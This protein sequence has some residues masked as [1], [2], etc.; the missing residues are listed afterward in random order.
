MGALIQRRAFII[1]GLASTH[2]LTS[3]RAEPSSFDAVVGN[4]GPISARRFATIHQAIDAAPQNPDRPF[5]IFIANGEW[6]ERLIIDKPMIHL[7]GESQ[8]GTLI[9]FDLAAGMPGEDGQPL[10]TWGCASVVIKAPGFGAH[11][12]TIENSFDYIGHL[13]RPRFERVGP[14]GAQAVAAM[15]TDQSDKAR[16]EHVTFLG[17]QDTLFIDRGRADFWCCAIFGSVDFIFGGGAAWFEQS[18]IVSRYRPGQ[19]RNHGYLSAP[20]TSVDLPFGFVFKNCRLDREAQVPDGA[21]VLGRPWRPTRQFAD[22]VY[23]DPKAVGSSYYVDCWMGA[24]ISADGWDEMGYTAPDGQRQMLQ[25]SDARFGESGSAGPGAFKNAR[26][27]QLPKET[28]KAITKH[29]V[30]GIWQ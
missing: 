17:H 8:D 14:N 27:P 7:F 19:Q 13:L 21:V 3:A 18:L 10:G 2:C 6:R 22:G 12:L 28:A 11:N 20:A 30:L 24:H 25:P 16:F 4:A 26:R 23:G 5:R 1:G 15:L 29:N 9:T